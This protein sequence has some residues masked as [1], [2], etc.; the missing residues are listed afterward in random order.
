MVSKWCRQNPFKLRNKTY[1]KNSIVMV[2]IKF[3]LDLLLSESSLRY[4]RFEN[5]ISLDSITMQNKF[6]GT[7]ITGQIN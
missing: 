2:Q 4:F 6:G 5:V 7:K 1:L 3:C